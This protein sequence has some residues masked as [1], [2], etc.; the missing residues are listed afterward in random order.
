MFQTR[1][2]A[3]VKQTQPYRHGNIRP[4]INPSLTSHVDWE[5]WGVRMVLPY[6]C[7]MNH[8]GII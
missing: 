8:T 4:I 2:N 1:F 5:I 6:W 3:L 7:T